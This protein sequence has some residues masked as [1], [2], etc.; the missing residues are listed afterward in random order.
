MVTAL[1]N[2]GAP[3]IPE[4]SHALDDHDEAVRRGAVDALI[5]IA[6][7]SPKAWPVLVGAL[8]NAHDDVPSRIEETIEANGDQAFAVKIVPLLQHSLDDPNQKV[9]GAS[10]VTLSYIL[11]V[12][13]PRTI[14]KETEIEMVYWH[15]PPAR[16]VILNV[17]K[18]LD[19]VNR[20][21]LSQ[22][23]FNL[24]QIGPAA[25]GAIPY[26]VPVLKD[27]DGG[28]RLSALW[29]LAAMG[30]AS[31]LP[32]PNIMQCL[33]DPEKSVRMKA[34]EVLGNC[35]L[36]AK[37][38]IP[39]LALQ[40]KNTDGDLSVQ[41]A[42]ALA[43]IDPHHDG[44]LP[45]VMR[46]FNDPDQKDRAM[47]ALR[48]MGN[49]ARPAAPA[50][51]QLIA[52]DL[53]SENSDDKASERAAAVTALARID[54]ADAI[55]ELQHVISTDK[56]DEV[57]I[58]AVTALGG[59]GSTTPRAISALVGALNNDSQPVRDAASEALSKLGKS[60]MPALI[61]A[62]KSPH[63]YQRAWP[64]RHW[65]KSNRCRP[66]SSMACGSRLATRAR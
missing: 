20:D 66:T 46:A 50:L 14:G 31:E 49:N 29:Y 36:A 10:A 27:R 47:T 16:D 11:A 15:G 40:L 1:G 2:A 63:I 33:K 8:G 41:A 65:A 45:L 13:A 7:G 58:A 54:G 52:T 56:D 39:E 64:S 57:R 5:V 51:M 38:A 30:S 25:K 21:K 35:G 60:A 44:V 55:P 48:E 26:V 42:L 61:A 32:V 28:T 62:L 3:A 37:N 17:A 34:M 43:N 9:R 22:I 4:L 53:D 59:L 23:I 19:R 6:R 12:S 18:S 24:A